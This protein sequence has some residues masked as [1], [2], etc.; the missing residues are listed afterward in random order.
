VLSGCFI[1]R[2]PPGFSIGLK[3]F[4]QPDGHFEIQKNSQP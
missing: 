4:Y 2:H 3:H 1:K